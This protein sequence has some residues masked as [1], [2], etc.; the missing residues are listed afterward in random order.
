MHQHSLP[1]MV[2][3]PLLH[4]LKRFGVSMF[5]QGM[6]FLLLFA[7]SPFVISEVMTM[8]R[9]F[10]TAIEYT[11]ALKVGSAACFEYIDLRNHN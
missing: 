3:P 7:F 8:I 9:T 5:L 10:T 2:I 6:N 11:T 1:R 4:M